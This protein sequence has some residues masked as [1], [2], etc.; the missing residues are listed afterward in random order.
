[1]YGGS[2]GSGE[3]ALCTG[4]SEPLL[5]ANVIST[6]VSCTVYLEIFARILFSGIALKDILV[7]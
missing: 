5:L 7:M 3:T 4:L 2:K 1:M 6:K